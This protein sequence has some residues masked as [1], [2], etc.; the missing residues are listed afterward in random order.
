MSDNPTGGELVVEADGQYAWPRELFETTAPAP[1]PTAAS[2][3]ALKE[4]AAA[5]SST[6]PATAPADAPLKAA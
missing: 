4:P 3:A 1:D 5:Q 6:D 2:P